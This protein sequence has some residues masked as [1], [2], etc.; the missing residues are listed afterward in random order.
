MTPVIL[1]FINTLQ[2]HS[3]KQ[4]D[5]PEIQVYKRLEIHHRVRNRPNGVVIE[6]KPF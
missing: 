1:I 5:P 6:L 2:F 4:I 3:D